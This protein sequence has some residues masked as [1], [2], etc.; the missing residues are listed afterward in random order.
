MKLFLLEILY[1]LVLLVIPPKPLF[2]SSISLSLSS[3]FSVL[4]HPFQVRCI[5]KITWINWRNPKASSSS[6]R[7]GNHS[8]HPLFDSSLKI[9]VSPARDPSLL[10]Y[11]LLFLSIFFIPLSLFTFLISINTN[12]LSSYQSSINFHPIIHILHYQI[13]TSLLSSPWSFPSSSFQPKTHLIP[14]SSL[15][16]HSLIHYRHRYLIYS[17]FIYSIFSILYHIFYNH[18]S[19]VTILY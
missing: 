12:R 10:S 5:T 17:Y 1:V 8:L 11:P 2:E 13:Q 6:S 7:S 3:S 19:I 14:L 15:H 18:Y 16:I 4:F 9:S